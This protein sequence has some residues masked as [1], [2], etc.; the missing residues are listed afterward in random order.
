MT[1]TE[2]QYSAFFV[3]WDDDL[4]DYGFARHIRTEDGTQHEG[5]DSIAGLTQWVTEAKAETG[6]IDDFVL[7]DSWAN[8]DTLIIHGVFVSV[9]AWLLTH[10]ARYAE[11][12]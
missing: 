5:W 9:S 6:S 12:R 4:E 3:S 2:K 10:E 11:S 1:T 7:Y 8:E